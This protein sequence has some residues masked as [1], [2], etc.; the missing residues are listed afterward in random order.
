M[1]ES[2]GAQIKKIRLQKEI[3]LEQIANDTGA[4][5]DHLEKIESGE[6]IPAVGML[7][8]IARSLNLDS[9]F[10]LKP[11]DPNQKD[12]AILDQARTSNYAY[13]TLTPGGEYKHLK[14]FKV[15]VEAG[16]EHSSI[17]YAHNG[18]EFVYVLQGTVEITVGDHKTELTVGESLHFN[19]AIKHQL[20][21]I[22]EDD[23]ELLVS[24]YAP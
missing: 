2:L 19:S 1:T 16:K 11:V 4:A 22:G 6:R 21:N 8:Q 20:R 15:S 5:I 24:I 14:V 10:F 12:R 3:T 7:L 23:A 9:S 17:G 18:E 13:Q